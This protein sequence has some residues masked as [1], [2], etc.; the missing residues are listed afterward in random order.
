M[1]LVEFD[2]VYNDLENFGKLL[3]STVPTQLLQFIKLAEHSMNIESINE[4]SGSMAEKYKGNKIPD[5]DEKCISIS[6]QGIDPG[7]I[8]SYN[9]YFDDLK[10]DYY[11]T[12][13]EKSVT[14]KE[15]GRLINEGVA[16]VDPDLPL[17]Y[18]KGATE[19]PESCSQ[20]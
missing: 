6:Q 16:E 13:I 15:V 2:R 4:E 14:G 7:T 1:S 11:N 8:Q 5:E 20:S 3:I 9:E 19:T 12:M 18:L 10:A 17:I